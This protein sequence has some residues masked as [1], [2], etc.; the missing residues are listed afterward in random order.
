MNFEAAKEM[1]IADVSIG[2]SIVGMCTMEKEFTSISSEDIGD[3]S[4]TG[5][6]SRS[7]DITN[8]FL[9][10]DTLKTSSS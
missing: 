3:S 8:V 1:G 10:L 9:V 7:G 5:A 6:K 2:G 4:H